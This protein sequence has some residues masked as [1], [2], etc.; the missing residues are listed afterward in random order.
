MPAFEKTMG[1]GS[2]ALWPVT[3][4]RL[5]RAATGQDRVQGWQA[6]GTVQ[7]HRWVAGW[8]GRWVNGDLLEIYVVGVLGVYPSAVWLGAEVRRGRCV[9]SVGH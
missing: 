3:A 7:A 6:G 1:R 5:D 4:L 8:L 2:W 9:R